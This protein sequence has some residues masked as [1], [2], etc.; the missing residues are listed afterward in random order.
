M[1]DVIMPS[2]EGERNLRDEV[3]LETDGEIERVAIHVEAL[4]TVGHKSPTGT[5]HPSLGNLNSKS[6]TLSEGLGRSE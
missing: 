3:C 1:A 4:D 2:S 5:T 6:P